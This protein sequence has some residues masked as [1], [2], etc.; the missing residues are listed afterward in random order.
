MTVFHF[1]KYEAYDVKG[2][3]LLQDNPFF[4]VN[5]K[6]IF[7]FDY[8][9]NTLGFPTLIFILERC[10]LLSKIPAEGVQRFVDI[11]LQKCFGKANQKYKLKDHISLMVQTWI[12]MTDNKTVSVPKYKAKIKKS[13]EVLKITSTDKRK[14]TRTPKGEK[15]TDYLK[16]T[17]SISKK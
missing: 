9:T 10:A 5:M 12:D 15:I 7:G 6:N 16:T 14:R 8:W 1:S 11:N 2:T 3:Y 4:L 13:P 17:K